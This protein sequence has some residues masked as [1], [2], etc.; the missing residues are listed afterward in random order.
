MCYV[1]TI[2][3]FLLSNVAV[4]PLQY[5]VN[6]MIFS[7]GWEKKIKK[8]RGTSLASWSGVIESH[9]SRIL[10]RSIVFFLSLSI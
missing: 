3:G 9:L 1:I 2:L 8:N 10:G 7:G 5:L 4:A 6:S